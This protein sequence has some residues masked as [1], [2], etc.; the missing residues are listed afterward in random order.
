[1]RVCAAIIQK[2]DQLKK[3]DGRVAQR[4]LTSGL[5]EKGT[6]SILNEYFL[7]SKNRELSSQLAS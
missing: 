5:L 6:H 3:V 2:S 4:Y 7:I 1:M